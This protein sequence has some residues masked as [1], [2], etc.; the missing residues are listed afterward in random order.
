MPSRRAEICS[1]SAFRS[2][3]SRRSVFR[4]GARDQIAIAAIGVVHRAEVE[5][6]LARVDAVDDELGVADAREVGEAL[7]GGLYLHDEP[8][9]RRYGE[10][11]IE[12]VARVRRPLERFERSGDALQTDGLR[13]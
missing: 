6:A 1:R 5:R 2:C 10:R 9:A 3:M 7:V 13:T 12:H 11:R 4:S 8:L